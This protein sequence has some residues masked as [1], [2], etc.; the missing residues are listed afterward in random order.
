[1]TIRGHVGEVQSLRGSARA[2]LG[3]G[4]EGCEGLDLL[5]EIKELQT[6]GTA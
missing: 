6:M 1:M 4:L 3:D 5:N 2:E